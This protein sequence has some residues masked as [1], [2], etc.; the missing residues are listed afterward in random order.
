MPQHNGNVQGTGLLL[1]QGG[2]TYVM[3]SSPALVMPNPSHTNWAPNAASGLVASD[4]HELTSAGTLVSSSNPDFSAAGGILQLGFW[5]AG[6]SGTFVGMD[7][8]DAG[9]DNWRVEIVPSPAGT[10]ALVAGSLIVI[11]RRR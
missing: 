11:R 7:F 4:F 2:A 5:R 9:I 8:R 3:R 10:A 1:V 6:S